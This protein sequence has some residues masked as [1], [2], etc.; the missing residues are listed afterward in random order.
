[1]EKFVKSIDAWWTRLVIDKLAIPLAK[2]LKDKKK[3]SPNGVTLF[4]LILSILASL[5]IVSLNKNYIIIGASVYQLAFL[6]DCIDGKLARLRKKTSYFGEILDNISDRISISAMA[7]AV[8]YYFSIRFSSM[9]YLIFYSVY[10]L[11]TLINSN[12]WLFYEKIRDKKNNINL[13]EGEVNKT[14]FHGFF[15]FFKKKGLRPYPS[16]IELNLLLFTILPILSVFGLSDL[17]YLYSTI[18]FTLIM[19]LV[20]IAQF[21]FVIR[22]MKQ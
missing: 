9:S 10:A 11:L 8:G 3:V 14:L 13:L 22:Q 12:V 16:E 20:V 19:L 18:F 4:S 2:F 1:M 5:L 21:W 7:L 17:F 6:F 15:L